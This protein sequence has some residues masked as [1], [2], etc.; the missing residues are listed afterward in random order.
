[1]ADDRQWDRRSL[2]RGAA[3]MTGAAAAAPLLG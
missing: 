3:V 1:M 2:L